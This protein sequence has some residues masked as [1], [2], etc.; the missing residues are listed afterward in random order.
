MFLY[1]TKTLLWKLI[2]T[3]VFEN[4]AL[5]TGGTVTGSPSAPREMRCPG[6]LSQKLHRPVTDA[7]RLLLA[8]YSFL[9]C[10]SQS[11]RGPA[12]SG[13]L[14]WPSWKQRGDDAVT[15]VCFSFH[16]TRTSGFVLCSVRKTKQ[17]L[18]W[19]YLVHIV[20]FV[21][22][23]TGTTWFELSDIWTVCGFYWAVW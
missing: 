19:S 1:G 8:E 9:E 23:V 10:T 3:T 22:V 13:N 2:F 16:S 20:I 4:H 17:V 5:N 7:S 18:C 11:N 15:S 6:V 12:S 14:C 21:K